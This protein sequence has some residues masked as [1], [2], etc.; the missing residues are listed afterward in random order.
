MTESTRTHPE[1]EKE[2]SLTASLD[3]DRE[4]RWRPDQSAP[5]LTTPEVAAAMAELVNTDFIKKF[6]RVERTYQDPPVPPTTGSQ[7]FGLV[8]FTPAKGAVPNEH[9]V[10]GMCK[11]R[12]NFATIPEADQRA[13]TI[14]RTADSYHHIYYVPVGRP[15]P[16]TLSPAYSAEVNELD[17][18]REITQSISSHIKEQKDK[19]QRVTQ[20]IKDREEK[21]LEESAEA[22]KDD[23]TGEPPEEDP[24]KRY[25]TLCV[26]KAQ[27]SWTFLEHL[28]KLH[29]VRDIIVKTRAELQD[30]DVLHPDFRSKYFQKYMDAREAA[31]LDTK[32][33]N[34][35]DNFI[36]FMVEEAHLPTIDT[37]EVLPAVSK[38][39][40]IWPG[41]T[42][43]QAVQ[44]SEVESV[45][46]A[47]QVSEVESVHEVD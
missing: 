12:G 45:H 27:L 8:S 14:I 44:V 6:P 10:Y 25:V 15:F 42:T 13:E 34:E 18:R 26:K 7:L 38:R 36:K 29:E 33:R 9:G 31:G 39:E 47:V 19:D 17:I 23:G 4:A 32:I 21:L 22:R 5:P 24:Y 35:Q 43:Q 2:N 1:W 41:E 28:K 11:L 46:E 37:D 30:S 3:R 20:E 16:M 40:V